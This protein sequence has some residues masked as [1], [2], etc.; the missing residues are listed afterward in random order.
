MSLKDVVDRFALVSN[1]EQEEISKWFFVILDCIKYFESKVNM[2]TLTQTQYRRI[3]HACAVYA[4][5]KY[6]LFNFAASS[7]KFKAGD[8]EIT[9]SESITDKAHI[10]WQQEKKE[11][12]DI[13]DFDGFC[14]TRVGA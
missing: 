7:Q 3:A 10:M 2:N 6:T 9:Q 11:I 4:Y 14:F 12:A 8:V 1:L 5:Y 13:I